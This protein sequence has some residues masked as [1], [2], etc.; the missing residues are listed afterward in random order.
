MAQ[1]GLQG[2]WMESNQDQH[3]FQNWVQRLVKLIFVRMS[4]ESIQEG[5]STLLFITHPSIIL[6]WLCLA[7]MQWNDVN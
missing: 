2:P 6:T 4:Y 5:Q 7:S 1:Y 3:D